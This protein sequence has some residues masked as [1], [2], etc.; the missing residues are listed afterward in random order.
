MMS[1]CFAVH[2]AAWL[3]DNHITVHHVF[4]QGGIVSSLACSLFQKDLF[5]LV[6]IQLGRGA[7]DPKGF[8][9]IVRSTNKS[10]ECRF[11]VV[12]LQ[13]ATKTAKVNLAS[14]A[15]TTTTAT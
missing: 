13:F 11:P 10:L 15:A 2:P 7:V 8:G 4:L 9:S 1:N 14:F 12:L 3:A 5:N 6:L